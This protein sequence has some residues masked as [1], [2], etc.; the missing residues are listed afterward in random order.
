MIFVVIYKTIKI[1][2]NMKKLMVLVAS[3]I[4]L[5]ATNNYAQRWETY[6]NDY[7][8]TYTY[9]IDYHA[10]LLHFY[11]Y[12]TFNYYSCIY[13]NY[14]YYWWFG[15]QNW[16]S[17]SWPW[18]W[19]YSYLYVY[20]P[21]YSYGYN[22]YYE[23]WYDYYNY[24]PN[25]FYLRNDEISQELNQTSTSQI[26]N[27]DNIIGQHSNNTMDYQNTLN[28]DAQNIRDNN[29]KSSTQLEH[30]KEIYNN[31]EKN[32]SKLSKPIEYWNAP[33]NTG[34]REP[35]NDFRGNLNRQTTHQKHQN[36]QNAHNNTKP[37]N[38]IRSTHI[39]NSNSKFSGQ[40]K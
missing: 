11:H 3:V 13:Y 24:P 2:N 29:Q 25:Y 23:Y 21:N 5:H 4:L 30:P 16:Y 40:R 10:R 36:P 28:S 26:D 32:N 1:L 38:Q 9:N 39:Y 35:F 31:P 15:Y 34:N 27:S 37:N 19:S 7:I 22:W 33:K 12:N 17:S 14:S 8:S 6:E 20:Y 18:P